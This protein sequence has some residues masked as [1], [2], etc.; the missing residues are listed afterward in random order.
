MG[1]WAFKTALDPRVRDAATLR[2][3]TFGPGF[4]NVLPCFEQR[5]GKAESGGRRRA[6]P[7]EATTAVVYGTG[8]RRDEG[9]I[10]R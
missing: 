6:A 4:A 5:A 8:V 2:R 3:P 1:T 9:G 10:V 7:G